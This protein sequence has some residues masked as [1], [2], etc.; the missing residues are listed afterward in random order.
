M[1]RDQNAGRSH[2]IKIDNSSC[3]RV[4]QFRYLGTALTDR[5]CVQ[6]EINVDCSQAMLVIIWWGMFCVAVW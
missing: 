1:S 4:E 5:K 6:E 3:G 2:N